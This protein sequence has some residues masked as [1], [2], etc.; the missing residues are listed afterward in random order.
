MP[1][2]VVPGVRPLPPRAGVCT[3]KPMR[4]TIVPRG[5]PSKPIAAAAIRTTTPVRLGPSRPLPTTLHAVGP[6]AK[7]TTTTATAKTAAAPTTIPTPLVRSPPEEPSQSANSG[8][9]VSPPARDALVDGLDKTSRYLEQSRSAI[10]ASTQQTD[11]APSPL[12]SDDRSGCRNATIPVEPAIACAHERVAGIARQGTL[13]ALVIY[14]DW[15]E[16]CTLFVPRALAALRSHPD[17]ADGALA[18]H[19]DA[20]SCLCAYY[21]VDAVPCI[22]FRARPRGPS[23]RWSGVPRPI[24][25]PHT[26]ITGACSDRVLA[27]RIDAA[28][29]AFCAI[30]P[31]AAITT[32]TTG[33]RTTPCDD[34]E[35]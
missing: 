26:R 20:E 28:V 15:S 9:T 6:S 11:A 23:W 21:A 10:E 30:V 12:E 22:I 34:A 13:G 17:L 25:I 1:L 33:P 18:V 4:S 24:E 35:T 16:A 2:D 14:A 8:A 29:A 19:V 27:A 7:T 5:I 3:V 31:P 32:M